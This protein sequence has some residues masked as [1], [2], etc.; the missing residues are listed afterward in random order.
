MSRIQVQLNKEQRVR[1]LREALGLGLGLSRRSSAE[2]AERF[3]PVRSGSFTFIFVSIPKLGTGTG[4]T[5]PLCSVQVRKQ[6][7]GTKWEGSD[8]LESRD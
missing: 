8:T 3:R 7:F 4:K 6:G 1:R 2:R 5:A